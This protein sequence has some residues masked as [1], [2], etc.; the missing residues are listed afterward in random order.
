MRVTELPRPNPI[1]SSL[2]APFRLVIRTGQFGTYTVSELAA[3]RRYVSLGGHL[4]LLTDFQRPGQTDT[5]AQTFG[6]DFRGISR[7]ENM[8]NHFTAH[9]ITKG[10][11]DI[12]YGVGSGLFGVP[13]S[14]TILGYLSAS[15][16]IDLNDNKVQDPGEPSGAPVMGVMHFGKGEIFFIGDVNI[17]EAVPQ[18]L[19]DNLLQFFDLS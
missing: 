16:F 2:L 7:G 11:S 5:L 12:P 6:L 1:D 15:T 13:P 4:F 19:V 8:I 10:L 9:S 14:V 18:P 17:M 3:Y